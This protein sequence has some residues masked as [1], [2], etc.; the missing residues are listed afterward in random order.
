MRHRC[1][2]TSGFLCGFWGYNSG[3]HSFGILPS[4]SFFQPLYLI[5]LFIFIWSVCLYACMFAH[6]GS[7]LPLW[8]SEKT[9]WEL[10]LSFH[11]TMW[12]GVLTH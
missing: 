5:Y 7:T 6:T 9:M 3:Y 10:S 12:P 4:K 1:L 11:P 2:A 8:R